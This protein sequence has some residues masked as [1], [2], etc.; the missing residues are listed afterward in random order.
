MALSARSRFVSTSRIRQA[1][2]SVTAAPRARAPATVAMIPVARHPLHMIPTLRCLP[3]PAPP[4][5]AATTHVPQHLHLIPALP[6]APAHHHPLTATLIP[7]TVIQAATHV[8]AAL[9]VH[10]HRR[11]TGTTRPPPLTAAA[12]LRRRAAQVWDVNEDAQ[13]SPAAGPTIAA[14][15]RFRAAGHPADTDHAVV[16]AR[17]PEISAALLDAAR[18]PMEPTRIMRPTR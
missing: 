16:V 1:H 7:A 10:P 13:N 17:A 3:A 8:R 12:R 18:L 6:P 4:T 2:T 11:G 14:A 5:A 15:A 9:L